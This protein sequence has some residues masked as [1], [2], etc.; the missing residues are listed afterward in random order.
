MANSF[1][2]DFI[3]VFCSGCPLQ[4]LKVFFCKIINKRFPVEKKIVFLLFTSRQLCKYNFQ[5]TKPNQG[6]YL[7]F[8]YIC[9]VTVIVI[10]YQP[11][12]LIL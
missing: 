2:N 5:G 11:N 7:T 4:L 1:R 10:V 3:F 8:V 12:M 9:I 6:F